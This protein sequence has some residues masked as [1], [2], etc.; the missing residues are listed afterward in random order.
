MVSFSVTYHVAPE[1]LGIVIEDTARQLALRGERISPQAAL[2]CEKTGGFECGTCAH[3]TPVNATHG[4][5][6]LV[7]T[8]VHVTDGCCVMWAPNTDMLHLYREKT[9]QD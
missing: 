8:T 5:C 4:R 1:T 3:M 6:A 2:Y 7:A 9:A